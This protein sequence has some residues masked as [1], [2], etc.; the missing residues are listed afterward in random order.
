MTAGLEQTVNKHPQ[1]VLAQVPAAATDRVA[2]ERHKQVCTPYCFSKAFRN[3]HLI[4]TNIT[5][6][7][8]SVRAASTDG[9][10]WRPTRESTQ[11]R[12]ESFHA[13]TSTAAF[14]YH[15]LMSSKEKLLH[16]KLAV[17]QLFQFLRIALWISY[18]VL[19]DTKGYSPCI[20]W[21]PIK[22]CKYVS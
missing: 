12:P 17:F 15:L 9:G 5:G 13:L 20:T 22:C 21:L 14:M 16:R 10:M 18:F 1:S 8:L 19:F 3:D 11:S 2:T 7:A 4:S 6:F